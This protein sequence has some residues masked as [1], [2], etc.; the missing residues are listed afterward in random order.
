MKKVVLKSWIVFLIGLIAVVS[1]ALPV[2]AA[3]KTPK[4]IVDG[5]TIAPM[6]PLLWDK[7]TILVSLEDLAAY[8]DASY[9]ADV[10]AGTT[11]IQKYGNTLL[12]RLTTG[13]VLKNSV[14][15]T[16][17]ATARI[18]EGRIYA[19]LRFVSEY[20]KATVDWNE[21]ESKVVVNTGDRHLPPERTGNQ[22]FNAVVAYTDKGSLWLLDGRKADTLPKQITNTGYA[23]I[24]GWSTDGKW[25]AYKYSTKESDPNYLWVARADGK[26][27]KQVDT[28]PIYDDAMWS[29][30]ENLL[31]YTPMQES[32]DGYISAGI[33]KS[34]D[35]SEKGIET[36]TLVENDDTMILSLA[37]HP[38]GESLAVSFPRTADRAPTIE[39]VNLTGKR[40]VLYTL[41]DYEPVEHDGLY[42]WAFIGLK[43]SPDGHYLAYHLRMNSGS[44]T[45]DV[46]TI[47]V[48]N[49]VN[50]QLIS[51]N[52]GLKY[53]EWMAFSPD[54]EKLA[55]IA[56]VGREV[57]LNKKLEI[58]DLASGKITD[59]SLEGHADTH[60]IWWDE[61]EKLL[62]CRGPEVK[63]LN[64]SEILPGV[65]V[66]RQSIYKLGKDGNVINLTVGSEK[67]ADYYPSPSP[68][69]K[70]MLFL[71]LNRF[72][73]GSL[74]L[75]SD[76]APEQAV[77]ILRGLR[78]N[79]GYYWNY[80]PM[81]L[82]VH[83][84]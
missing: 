41:K 28:L 10:T 48:L 31:V 83:W 42:S 51:L 81:W 14:P 22:S 16:P 59:L 52:D 64:Q 82:S 63:T 77:E 74:Y 15:I 45:A 4:L 62:F 72:N 34:A 25:L 11:W 20:L 71:R 13:E 29:P 44:L 73:Q 76:D 53:R 75:Q 68:A 19:P 57:P 56:G 40:K 2:M 26:E 78:G 21:S 80:Y 5:E 18:I 66:P 50:G 1:V 84:F 33:V 65:L 69:V 23:E 27:V 32:P 17:P 6:S 67:T 12:F 61:A 43:W 38:D 55:Y 3:V 9:Q 79:P 49:T 7:G 46:V 58:V 47:G 30:K 37:W 39:Q 60:P 8:I 70:E 54:G 36:S 24:I 35:I